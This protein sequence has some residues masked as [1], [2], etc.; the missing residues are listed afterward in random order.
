MNKSESIKN[1]ATALATFQVKAEKIIKTAENPFFKSKYADLPS[2]LDAIA[3][4]LT[5]SGLVVS[6]FPDG[7][8]LTTLLMHPNSGEWIEATGTMKP[9]KSDPQAI[10]SA[11]TYQRRYSLC[12]VLGLNVDVDDD[13]NEA[14]AP[15]PPKELDNRPWF[16]D[17][18]VNEAIEAMKNGQATLA[19]IKAKYRISKANYAKLTA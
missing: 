5:E 1:I 2:I 4:P 8:G 3:L 19:D 16:P 11:I 13:G 7:D 15:A 18:K 12:A 6:Q 9:V 10:G 17:A 14:S